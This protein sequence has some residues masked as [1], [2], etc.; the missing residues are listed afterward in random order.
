LVANAKQTSPAIKTYRVA[1]WE[2]DYKKAYVDAP[3]Q[4]EA[5]RLALES[6]RGERA[7]IDWRR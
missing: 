5:E 3:T 4:E 7:D 6:L 2:T 1:T